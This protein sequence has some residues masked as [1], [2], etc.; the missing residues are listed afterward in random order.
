MVP[1]GMLARAPNQSLLKLGK[2]GGTREQKLGYVPS[3]P[4]LLL[5]TDRAV[6]LSLVEN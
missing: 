4:G 3:F 6:A 2:L 5:K 1:D